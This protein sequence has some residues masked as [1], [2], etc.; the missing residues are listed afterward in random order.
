M[1]NSRAQLDDAQQE[2]TRSLG[3]RSYFCLVLCAEG[4]SG[5]VVFGAEGRRR[6]DAMLMRAYLPTCTLHCPALYDSVPARQHLST[7]ITQKNT[8]PRKKSQDGISET[9]Y[10]YYTAL[11]PWD[12]L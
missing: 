5:D 9:G 11:F 10:A 2:T 8:Q 3:S 4:E 6:M 12:V 7:P 1:Y